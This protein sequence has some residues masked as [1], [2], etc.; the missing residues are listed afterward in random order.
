[1]A[2]IS[3][4][5]AGSGDWSVASNWSG[6]TEPGAADSVFLSG[7]NGYTVT[8]DVADSIAAL[9]LSDAAA[10][11]V[12]DQALS[13]QTRLSVTAG[14]LLIEG[15]GGL[16]GGVL[17]IGTAASATLDGG[18]L[19]NLSVWGTLH[20]TDTGGGLSGNVN[21]AGA[22]GTGLGTINDTD[23]DYYA[24]NYFDTDGNTRLSGAT[25]NIGNT[26]TGGSVNILFADDAAGTGATLIFEKNFTLNEVAGNSAL[27]GTDGAND[28]I[29][30]DGTISAMTGGG[31]LQIDATRFFN[32][33]T[34][35]TANG[36]VLFFSGAIKASLIDSV[37]IGTG[38]YVGIDG[39]VTGGTLVTPDG[40]IGS[41]Q[42][43]GELDSVTV[44]GTLTIQDDV[45]TLAGRNVFTGAGGTGTGT[46]NFDLGNYYSDNF[47]DASGS[48]TL[49]NVVLNIGNTGLG[50]SA[51]ILF[52]QDTAGNG[53]VLTLGP[54]F[55]FNAVAGN[56]G[57]DSS[58]GAKDAIVNE[59]T[60]DATTGGATLQ[61]DGLHFTNKGVID[62]ANGGLVYFTNIIAASLLDSVTTGAGGYAGID[63]TVDGGTI[64]TPD[65]QIGSY[66]GSGVLNGVAVH[67]T[68]TIEDSGF[69]LE[70]R[71]SFAGTNGSGAGAL[72]FDEGSAYQNAELTVLGSA[73][74][75]NVVLTIGNTGLG[76]SENILFSNDD[77]AGATLTLGKSFT[78]DAVAGNSVIG[79]SDG[80]GDAIVNYGV[81]NASTDGGYLQIDAT[82]FTNKGIISTNGGGIVYFTGTIAASLIDSV[83]VGVGTVAGPH[84]TKSTPGGYVGID[85]TVNGGVIKSSDGQVGSWG[86]AGVLNSVVV[87]GTLTVQDSGFTLVGNNRF[88]GSGGSGVGTLD[89]DLGNY[90][91]TN[92]LWALGT[93]TLN[94][95]LLN[96]GNTGLGGSTN[97]LFNQDK[98][99]TGATLTLG[100]TFTLNAVAG[101]SAIG[102]T[103]GAGDEI[104]NYGTIQA[105]TKG[106]T[107]NID[108]TKFVN[109]G[110]IETANGG[111]ITL[112]GP[113]SASLIDSIAVGKGGFVN[114]DGLVTGGTLVCGGAGIGSFGGGGLSGV[115]VQGTLY[116]EG[117]SFIIEGN[118]HFAGSGG[119]GAGTI[120]FDYGSVSQ[121]NYLYLPGN[122]TLA[123]VI[124]NI[125]NTGENG[126]D[127]LYGDDTTNTGA[128]LTLASSFTMNLIHGVGGIGSSGGA[129][130]A[131]VNDGVINARASGVLQITPANFTN[132]GLLD[133]DDGGTLVLTAGFTN[134]VAGTLT[135]GNIVVGAGGTLDLEGNSNITTVAADLTLSGA[136][137][138][139]QWL[140]PSTDRFISF[141]SVFTTLEAGGTLS[142]LAGRSL[143]SANAIADDGKLVLGGGTLTSA[144][145][146]IGASAALTGSGS[147]AGTVSL[148]AKGA[149]SA[150][151]GTLAVAGDVTGAGVLVAGA[152]ASLTIA[153]NASAQ[154]VTV[155]AGG[156]FSVAGSVV[157][158]GIRLN[159]TGAALAFG[160]AG[161]VH[162][163]ISGF[164]NGDTID[165]TQQTLSSVVWSQSSSTGGS[166]TL[167]GSSGTLGVLLLSGSYAQAN[168]EVASDLHHI[169]FVATSAALET[170]H[171]TARD[172]LGVHGVAAWHDA[173]SADVYGEASP[174]ALHHAMMSGF[175]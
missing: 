63:G 149:L 46:L 109:K 126:I 13:V 4:S 125:G 98:T 15:G 11:L 45:F 170:I 58:N 10:A 110:K 97:V 101:N 62:T 144:G 95:V 165:I 161:S 131:V 8:L 113:A 155:D 12:L 151:G 159:G 136:T 124:V 156:V 33:G 6:G 133:A 158:D 16:S 38:G 139:L 53:A 83:F 23:G 79:S 99:G 174:L 143:T 35:E 34:I 37:V 26:G 24:D 71:N 57:I 51:N 94:N 163:K 157:A 61:I 137:S 140:D 30:N 82:K 39:T 88:S 41:Y 18:S 19:S 122:T 147:I 106:G 54:K 36:G 40:Q 80:A 47:L 111:T 21:F 69:T 84:G 145:L 5:N 102:G 73:T 74:L 42:G 160:T 135:G 93:Q 104:I 173:Y 29:V 60:I 67:G 154:D 52:N 70:G 152:A 108:T 76:G 116:L 175:F 172:V 66:G 25:L 96:I 20:V 65:G 141:D 142:L 50:G 2:N 31:D 167:I 3:W 103:D 107:L 105:T 130:D 138:I 85:G 17:S 120:D 118:T 1:M 9:T 129:D 100:S 148:A 75:N 90:Y 89:F 150:S 59:G 121:S 114:I 27:E 81:I 28:A 115:A 127:I 7:T 91:S 48:E 171:S 128:T 117:G 68:L 119:T 164:G 153:G 112:T 134:L 132:A 32:D 64:V 77:G 56:S 72:N 92:Y 162:A 87:Q 55:T 166:L 78:L 49:D 86:G 44:Q 43:S 14:S 168:F 169:D 22:G 123:N 146:A